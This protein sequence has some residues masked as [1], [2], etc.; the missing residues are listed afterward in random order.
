MLHK[1]FKEVRSRAFV[2][3]SIESIPLGYET[4]YPNDARHYIEVD[5]IY[6]CYP[7]QVIITPMQVKDIMK[8]FVSSRETSKATLAF[9]GLI[10]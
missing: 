5:V 3:L 9:G 7:Y 8:E 2:S 6:R 4:G 10:C 1:L